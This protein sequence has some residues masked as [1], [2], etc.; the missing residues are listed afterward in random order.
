MSF[1]PSNRHSGTKKEPVMRHRLLERTVVRVGL[2]CCKFA[3]NGHEAR[4]GDAE[5]G[6]RARD[7]RRRSAADAPG[8][9]VVNGEEVSEPA[10]ICNFHGSYIV[11]PRG[12]GDVVESTEIAGARGERAAEGIMRAVK[13]G[14]GDAI[15]TG[16]IKIQFTLRCAE[17][18]RDRRIGN[19]LI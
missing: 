7:I 18:R 16:E 14:D 1:P 4:T 5:Q 15:S 2:A 10:I 13:G 12:D 3:A 8:G 19:V 9:K 17:G 6:K 11:Q